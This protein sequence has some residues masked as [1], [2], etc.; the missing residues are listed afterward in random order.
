[1]TG[2]SPAELLMGRQ[3]KS[4]ISLSKPDWNRRLC[5]HHENS[6]KQSGAKVVRILCIGEPMWVRNYGAGA[7]WVQG[8]VVKQ[9]GPMSYHVQ[10]DSHGLLWKHVDQIQTRMEP[11]IVSNSDNMEKVHVPPIQPTEEIQQPNREVALPREDHSEQA[12]EPTDSIVESEPSP[13]IE[14]QVVIPENVMPTPPH[15]KD[16]VTHFKGPKGKQ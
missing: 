5:S 9:T 16:Y 7:K 10:T 14:E 3:L 13:Q 12:A 15:L 11:D 4:V 8:V 2:Q 6:I 1:M